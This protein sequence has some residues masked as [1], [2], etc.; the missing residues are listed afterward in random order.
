MNRNPSGKPTPADW[1]ERI[2]AGDKRALSKALS[3]VESATDTG[4]AL[5]R[6]AMS[7]GGK[8]HLVGITG[9]P[10]VGKSTLLQPLVSEWR[11]RDKTVGVLAV[12]PSSPFSGGAILGDRVRMSGG[13]PDH[14]VFFRSVASRGEAGGLAPTTVQAVEL[15][16]AAGFDVVLIETV[17]AGQGD[18]GIAFL[19]HT[20]L[21]LCAPD[22][23]D[24]I[25]GMKAGLMLKLRKPM[26]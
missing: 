15:M 22:T 18:V 10:G 8:A 3:E 26:P 16:D 14:G 20:R 11:A 6:A 23:G 2:Q 9:A 24:Q 1:L 7:H 21:V 5:V 12:D 17:G 4:R 13:Q 19:A 25:Q